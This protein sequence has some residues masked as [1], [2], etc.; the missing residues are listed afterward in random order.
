VP[1]GKIDGVAD[2]GSVPEGAR[3][4]DNLG[5]KILGG[6]LV[7]NDGPVG[8]DLLLADARPFHEAEG[9]LA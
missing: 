4:L 3:R 1:H 2:R 8:D 6:G 7:A 9:D 5:G